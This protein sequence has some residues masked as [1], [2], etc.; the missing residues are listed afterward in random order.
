MLIILIPQPQ[1]SSEYRISTWEGG[2]E[3][4][5]TFATLEAARVDGQPSGSSREAPRIQVQESC[6]ELRVEE[7]RGR[8]TETQGTR[9]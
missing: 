9:D 8:D 5:Q 1:Y 2:S 3:N 4:S 6:E 7:T